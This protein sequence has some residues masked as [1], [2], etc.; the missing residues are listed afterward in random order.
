[1]LNNIRQ[2]KT[3]GARTIVLTNVADLSQHINIEENCDFVIDI[4]RVEQEEEPVEDV[5]A[6]L[7]CLI[8]L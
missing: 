5:M 1:V 8:P 2:V 4:G 3:R 6:G 7:R